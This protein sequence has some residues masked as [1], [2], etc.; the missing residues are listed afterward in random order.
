[1][2]HRVLAA[3]FAAGIA[4][5]ISLA[6]PASAAPDPLT[7]P[8]II[9]APDRTVA[10]ATKRGVLFSQALHGR[11]FIARADE[12]DPTAPRYFEGAVGGFKVYC[13]ALPFRI[14]ILLRNQKPSARCYRDDDQD[15][16]F[17]SEAGIITASP[18]ATP[19]ELRV[20]EVTHATWRE[21]RLPYIRAST[22]PAGRLE[23]RFQPSA[24]GPLPAV[25]ETRL[26]WDKPSGGGSI[27]RFVIL[28]GQRFLNHDDAVRRT[29]PTERW[30]ELQWGELTVAVKLVQPDPIAEFRKPLPP[31]DAQLTLGGVLFD[32]ASGADAGVL[33][34]QVMQR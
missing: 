13:A 4:A 27:C 12:N 17:D 34:V 19:F 7:F 23:V 29:K 5:A 16:I 30:R 14:A 11:A 3:T 10:P 24:A 21:V 28:P 1:V 25:L 31:G 2:R 33:Q 15:S 22:A 18:R 6:S 9:S 32:R 8:V 20:E 26:C